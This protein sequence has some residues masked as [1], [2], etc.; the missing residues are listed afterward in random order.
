M[1]VH[2]FFKNKNN[3]LW[4][5]TSVSIEL[6]QDNTEMRSIILKTKNLPRKTT[7]TSFQAQIC[8]YVIKVKTL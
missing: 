5:P 6:T 1:I 3:S 2:S 8:G 4:C 7:S